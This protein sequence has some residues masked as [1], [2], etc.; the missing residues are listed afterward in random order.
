MAD[1]R[2]WVAQ[3]NSWAAAQLAQFCSAAPGES[4][5]GPRAATALMDYGLPGGNDSR[6]VVYR[7]ERR[8]PRER[9]L[10]IARGVARNTARCP[11][12]SATLNSAFLS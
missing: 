11:P 9:E 1:A 7:C 2:A 4:Q 10:A 12:F 5:L 8:P 6:T 3:L